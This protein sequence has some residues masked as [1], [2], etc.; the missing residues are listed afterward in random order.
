F[1]F[2][3]GCNPLVKESFKSIADSVEGG[4]YYSLQEAHEL[5]NAIVEILEGVSDLI[6]ADRRVLAFYETNDGSFDVA[7]AALQLDL[8][9]REMKTSL[10]RLLELGKIARWP[11]GRPLEASQAGIAVVMGHVP[12]AIVAGKPFKYDIR[13]KNPSSTVVGIRIIVSLITEDGVSEVTNE[14]H[15]VSPNSDQIIGM[16][17][18]PMSFEKGKASL[19][20]QVFH[21]SRSLQTKIY[22]TRLY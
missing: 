15:E 16:N 2:V 22:N 13:V 4:R 20:I 11:K 9:L 8:E 21:G 7:A 17:L 19:R 12:D 18:V 1:I 10:S 5:P 6:E 3:C 14:R